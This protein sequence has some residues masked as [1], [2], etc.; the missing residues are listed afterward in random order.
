MDKNQEYIKTTVRIPH[1]T[2]VKIRKLQ[3]NRYVSSIQH[4]VE[5]G[6]EWVVAT[7][8]ESPKVETNGKDNGTNADIF[9][10]R[11]VLRKGKRI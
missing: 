11:V 1:G 6:F 8:Q 7:S 10:K 5:L 3:K 4:A 2:W 9:K